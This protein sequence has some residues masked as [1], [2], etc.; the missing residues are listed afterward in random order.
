MDVGQALTAFAMGLFAFQ[1]RQ[2]VSELRALR[3]D[4]THLQHYVMKEIGYEPRQEKN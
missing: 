4:L 3:L 2:V 1:A